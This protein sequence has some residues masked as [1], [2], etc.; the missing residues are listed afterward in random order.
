M[1]PTAFFQRKSNIKWTI[2]Q[3]ASEQAPPTTHHVRQ[4]RVE[5]LSVGLDHP[6]H[7][8]HGADAGLGVRRVHP[9]DGA[10]VDAEVVQLPRAVEAVHADVLDL[11][12]L[13]VGAI[14]IEDFQP[15]VAC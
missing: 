13:L 6:L 14:Q 2:Q 4:A 10:P 3:R 11:S 9:E 8:A 15:Y 12:I 1:N 7:V 5:Q